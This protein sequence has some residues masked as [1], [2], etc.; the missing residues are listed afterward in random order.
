MQ[1]IVPA[2]PLVEL[3]QCMFDVSIDGTVGVVRFG[4][5]VAFEGMKDGE[6]LFIMRWISA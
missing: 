5:V 4:V 6:L 2:F 1:L 3:V